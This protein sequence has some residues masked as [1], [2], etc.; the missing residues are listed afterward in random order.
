MNILKMYLVNICL[1]ISFWGGADQKH[2][3]SKD[4]ILVTYSYTCL[5]LPD[6][7]LCTNLSRI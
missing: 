5:S 3:T 6:A 2:L 4:E 1:F 7:F